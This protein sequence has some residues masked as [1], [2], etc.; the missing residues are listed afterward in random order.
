MN[1]AESRIFKDKWS[2]KDNDYVNLKNINVSH[3]RYFEMPT[4]LLTEDFQPTDSYEWLRSSVKVSLWVGLMA[5]IMVSVLL[6]CFMVSSGWDEWKKRHSWHDVSLALLDEFSDGKSYLRL[7][8]NTVLALFSSY[9]ML[10][11]LAFLCLW[12]HPILE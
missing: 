11:L 1:D 7:V 3:L 6:L 10:F 8:G 5:L 12:I 9:M 4:N 2:D